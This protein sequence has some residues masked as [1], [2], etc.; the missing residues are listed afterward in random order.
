MRRLISYILLLFVVLL[1]QFTFVYSQSASISKEKVA[2]LDEEITLAKQFAAEQDFNQAAFYYGKVANT[3]WQHDMLMQAAENFLLALEMSDKLGNNNAVYIISTNLG[4][5][6]TDTEEY[7]KALEQ[8]LQAAAV[9]SKLGRK[10]DVASSYINQ[11]NIYYEKESYSKALNALHTANA[12]AQELNEPKLLRNIYSVFTKVYDKQGNI[13]ESAKYFNLFSA[14]TKKIQ[15]DELRVKEEAAR[16]LVDDATSRV[17][18]VEAQKQATEQEL[19]LKDEELTQ[20]QRVLEEAERESRERLM[21]I[22]LLNKER[23]LQQ[24]VITHQNQMRNIYLAIIV[25]VLFFTAYVLYSY[26]QKK[27]ANLLLQQKNEEIVRQNGEIQQQAEQLRELNSLKDKLFSIISHDLRS[28]LG[29]LI[30]LLNLT[31]QGFFTEEGFKEVIDELSKNVGYTSELLENLLKWAQS[32]MQ[33]LKVNPTKFKVHDI[34]QSKL[35]L[36]AEQAHNKGISLRNLIEEDVEVFADSAMIE[37]VFRNLIANAI[38]FCE[39]GSAVTVSA[40]I[41]NSDIMVSVADTGVG[42]SNEQLQRLFGREI[43]ST[44]GTQN[45]KGTGLG[46]ILCKDF[47]L[48]NNGDIW[49]KSI[50]GV[51]SEF[52]F[53]IP[54]AHR[55]N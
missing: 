53:T 44:R 11:A 14:I 30:T 29:S 40:S 34:A 19:M 9:A 37:L 12:I 27:R 20:K 23:E 16:Q 13:E 7:D 50:E 4:L 41:K 21:Q 28:P 8:F 54:L 2:Q 5:I 48:L 42:M 3:Y 10:A 47:V 33:G 6:Y 1:S 17:K 45:E 46:L 38:K 49:V 32:Q 39:K 55:A 52:F 31:Q 36:Y 15:Q 18:H 24:A 26:Y 25:L 43:F 35:N 22:D 51:G